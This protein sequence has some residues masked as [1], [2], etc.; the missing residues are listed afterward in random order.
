MKYPIFLYHKVPSCSGLRKAICCGRGWERRTVGS[1]DE[2][3]G[4]IQ[5]VFP[6]CPSFP[7]APINGFSAIAIIAALCMNYNLEMDRKILHIPGYFIHKTSIA[8]LL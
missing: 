6:V 3:A 8:L 7:D 2:P 4:E 5:F 1:A